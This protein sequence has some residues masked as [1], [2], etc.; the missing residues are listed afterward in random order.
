MR[1]MQI[2][3]VH[4]G[5]KPDKGSWWSEER[6]REIWESFDRVIEV[7]QEQQVD[8]LL[9]AGDL[10]H[11]P[12]TRAMLERV[13][14]SLQRLTH[15]T[16]IM[17][18]GNHDY[19]MTASP[20]DIY[21]F[22]SNTRCLS[23]ADWESIYLE[24][25]D[26]CITGI[27]YSQ[28]IEK[29][30]IY[31]DIEPNQQDCINILL[32]HG[33]DTM[34]APMN[35]EKLKWSGFDY[36]ALGHIHKPEMI[37]EDLMAYSGSLEPLDIN[38]IGRRGYIIG[39][40]DG[41][42]TQI[43]WYPINKRS[44]YRLEIPVLPEHTQAELEKIVEERIQEQGMDNI[45][46]IYWTGYHGEGGVPDCH[47]L[48]QQYRISGTIDATRAEYDIPQLYQDNY[49][50]LLGYYIAALQDQSDEISQKALQF[51]VE[52]MLAT[53]NYK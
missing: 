24:Q 22:S 15:T 34:H 20:Y 50:N 29:R 21:R 13:D 25:Y 37:Y 47:R 7:A 10:F 45:Y 23:H 16:T 26:V 6:E 39:E 51:G 42:G 9:I 19:R 32:A 4:L 11:H 3:D 52:A 46:E 28:K 44:Y 43:K 40:M 49:E 27:S 17:I 30:A 18:A 31:D 14:A 35:C 1:F 36:I 38:E 12:P 8:I 2:A 41:N 48:L 33:G 53:G 5:A